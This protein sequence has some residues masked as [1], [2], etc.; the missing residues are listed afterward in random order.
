MFNSYLDQLVLLSKFIF[1]DIILISLKAIARRNGPNLTMRI[2]VQTHG[3]GGKP[4]HTGNQHKMLMHRWAIIGVTRSRPWA[5]KVNKGA[6]AVKLQTT[7]TQT[8]CIKTKAS[9]Q[10]S[11]T[12]GS[13]WFECYKHA[14]PGLPTL[15]YA[16]L[17]SLCQAIWRNGSYVNGARMLS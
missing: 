9:K 2:A 12:A 13:S 11:N 10:Q 6:W 8:C 17:T 4:L 7:E 3:H 15:C 14:F 16:L 5:V 1:C